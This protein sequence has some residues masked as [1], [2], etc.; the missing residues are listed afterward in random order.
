VHL[1]GFIIRILTE[2]KTK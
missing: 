2:G 1:I